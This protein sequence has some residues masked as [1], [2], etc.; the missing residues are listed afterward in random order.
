MAEK[1]SVHQV[2]DYISFIYLKRKEN[3]SISLLQKLLYYTQA[4]Y[5]GMHKKP[6]FADDFEAWTHGPVCRAIDERFPKKVK[7]LSIQKEDLDLKALEALPESVIEH[8]DSVLADFQGLSLMKIEQTFLEYEQPWKDARKD[9]SSV[10]RNDVI[11]S[12]ESM[13]EFY[14]TRVKR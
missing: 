7:T 13:Y 1:I 4:W 3:I 9:M 6:L 10:E 2:A 12:K 8:I 14:R 5:L 11:I